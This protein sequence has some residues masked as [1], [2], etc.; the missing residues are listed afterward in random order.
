MKKL[1]GQIINERYVKHEKQIKT[2]VKTRY[3][4]KKKLTAN[5]WQKF[6]NGD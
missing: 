2:I 4:N 6:A 5:K 3:V 1:N